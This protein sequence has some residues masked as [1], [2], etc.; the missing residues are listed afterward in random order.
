MA[1]LKVQSL[2]RFAPSTW[3]FLKS[4][5][6]V[7]C[8]LLDFADQPNSIVTTT[9]LQQLCIDLVPSLAADRRS[10]IVA[11]F[12][13]LLAL[14]WVAVIL[15][16][17]SRHLAAASYGIDD[18]L[19]I[20][21]L[22]RSPPKTRSMASILNGNTD[23]TLGFQHGVQR[24]SNMGCVLIEN[25]DLFRNSQSLLLGAHSYA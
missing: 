2:S 4:T 6:K 14:S 9:S 10:N 15:R 23:N 13:L 17:V 1:F 18:C 3:I 25:H 8:Q 7:P 5:E 12:A 11:T 20:A 24:S 16:Y 21:A 19:I 22:V